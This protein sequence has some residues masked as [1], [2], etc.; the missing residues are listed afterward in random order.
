MSGFLPRVF[1]L[2]LVVSAEAFLDASQD[3][4][5]MWLDSLGP[6]LLQ[7]VKAAKNV[8]AIVTSNTPRRGERTDTIAPP[9]LEEEARIS[10]IDP[11]DTAGRGGPRSEEHSKHVVSNRRRHLSMMHSE[12]EIFPQRA[13]SYIWFVDSANPFQGVA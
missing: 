10:E 4:V 13:K 9:V 11:V 1:A 5:F 3:T 6:Q 8:L 7:P 12:C 2:Q